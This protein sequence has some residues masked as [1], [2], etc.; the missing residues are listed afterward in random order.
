[1]KT[2]NSFCGLM[3]GLVL[4]TAPSQAAVTQVDGS[5]VITGATGVLV[6]GSLYDVEFVTGTCLTVF[7]NC[8]ESNHDFTFST[9]SD[10]AAASQALFDQVFPANSVG[11]GW[12]VTVF[13][14]L[15]GNVD[16]G[17]AA[18]FHATNP[19]QNFVGDLA[20]RNY[21]TRT[22]AKWS[23][24][25]ATIDTD[26]DG[27]SDEDETNIYG[28]DPNDADS[29]NDGLN[30]GDELGAGSNP[31][32]PDSDGDGLSDGSDPEPNTFNDADGDGLGDGMEVLLGTDPN[33]ADSDFDGLLDGTEVDPATGT[34]PLNPDSDGD[35]VSDGDEVNGLGT[36]PN[37]PDSDGDGVGDAVDPLPNDPGVTSGYTEDWLRMI[38]ADA[39]AYDLSVIDA[40]NN[41]A[42]KGRR[43]ALSNKLNSAANAISAGNYE[44]AIES[45]TS[46]LQKLDDDDSPKDWML[47]SPEK[48]LLRS[49]V[50]QLIYLIGLL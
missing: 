32:N 36:N 42:A 26:G 23:V 46:L 11:L 20:D 45:L 16:F 38:S 5:G 25:T 2:K 4:F 49:D 43:N 39:L 21:V 27:I 31:L 14:V 12:F 19:A 17:R 15:G 9:A 37:N 13:D 3:L 47:S 30:D 48:T 7:I 40:N 6:S 1:M 10:A 28:T 24:S 44:N 34:D 8:T 35:G 33:N 41:N 29:D 18:I 50:E 22:F